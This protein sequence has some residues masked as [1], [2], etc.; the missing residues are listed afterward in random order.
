MTQE[1]NIDLEGY[2]SEALA[3][4][5][6]VVDSGQLEG[7]YA[8]HLAPSGKMTATKKMVGKLPK[9]KRKEFG[10]AVNMLGG[11]LNKAFAARK[12]EVA[13][14]ELKERIKR[15]MVDVTVPGR[16]RLLGGY[17]PSTTTLREVLDIFLRMGFD[18][19][20]TPHVERDDYNFTFLNMPPDHPARD[21]QDTFYIDQQL[22]LRTHTSP[23]Q[24]R[25]MRAHAPNPVRAV[26]PGMCYRYEAVTPRSEMQFHQVEGL[27]V[28][29]RVRFSDL[30]GVLLQFARSIFGPDQD[31]RFRGSYFPFTE[32]SVEVD[33]KCTMCDGVG[34]RVCKKTGWLELLGAGL[35]HPVVLE[36][37]GY[38]P[39]EFRGIAF[40]MGIE[41]TVLLRH[42]IN[43]IRYIFQNDLRLLRQ[44]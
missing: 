25:T 38:D 18:V 9:D 34:C 27:V 23:G 19:V 40:G 6:D 42:D 15:E 12:A 24:I 17:H 44:F 33:V 13:D 20:E 36:N 35:V 39:S 7:W 21:M 1:Q 5:K 3:E 32:P 10:K 43:D 31:I 29:K 37:G 8:A 16:E 30:K 22:L 2:R 14:H 41:R 28:G 26:L 4:L 11:A